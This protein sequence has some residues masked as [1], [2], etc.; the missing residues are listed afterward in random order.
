VLEFYKTISQHLGSKVKRVEKKQKIVA[1][2][3]FIRSIIRQW[4]TPGEEVALQAS[5]HSTAVKNNR[6]V[7]HRN[8]T[9]QYASF[10]AL[11]LWRAI[12]KIL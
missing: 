12:V 3:K 8:R 6:K 5:Q 9:E 2:S 11:I 1:A 7:M 4:N 10:G